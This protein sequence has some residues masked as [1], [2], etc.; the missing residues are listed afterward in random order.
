MWRDICIANRDRVLDELSHYEKKLA[1]V[2]GLLE[3]GD[4]A[5]LEQLFTEAREA[6][7]RWLRASS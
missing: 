4:A 1:I 2:K 5:A 7:N 3:T 6:R